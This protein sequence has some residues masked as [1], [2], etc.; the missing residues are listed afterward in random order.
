MRK[1]WDMSDGLSM[2]H[3]PISK[4]RANF[5]RKE[6]ERRKKD[7]PRAERNSVATKGATRS[8][9]NV[10]GRK[11]GDDLPSENTL[12]GCGPEPGF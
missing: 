2:G 1:F 10:V 5:G 8:K 4:P 9:I 12:P 3:R 6:S 11:R 7:L